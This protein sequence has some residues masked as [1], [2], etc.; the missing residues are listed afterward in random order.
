MTSEALRLGTSTYPALR[1]NIKK[2]KKSF[3]PL[4]CFKLGGRAGR[5]GFVLARREQISPLPVPGCPPLGTVLPGLSARTVA[6]HREWEMS[7]GGPIAQA[8]PPG[9]PAGM[10][11]G[12]L[13]SRRASA[14]LQHIPAHLER[15]AA[16]PVQG[17]TPAWRLWGVL[18]LV[19][20]RS[21]PHMEKATLKY[22]SDST[23]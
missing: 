10:L 11:L 1:F 22:C 18:L 3:S 19:S 4:S 21:E 20:T 23:S 8:L 15:D 14:R 9:K 7:W 5:S 12:M 16:A 2:K 17:Q 13:L 6:I